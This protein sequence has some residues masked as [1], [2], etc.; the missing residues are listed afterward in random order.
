MFHVA[1]LT[2]AELD[3]LADY[4]EQHKMNGMALILG[5]D[6]NDNSF[7]W[8]TE[9]GVWTPPVKAEPRD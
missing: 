4:I 5:F 6:H 9:Y 1:K 3:M 7:K 2:C 8:K